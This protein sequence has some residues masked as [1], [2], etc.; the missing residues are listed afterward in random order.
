MK[1]RRYCDE[2]PNPKEDNEGRFEYLCC[3][4][5]PDGMGHF[6]RKVDILRFCVLDSC[7]TLDINQENCIVTHWMPMPHMP[8]ETI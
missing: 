2:Y 1:W 4:L 5:V 8:E 3:V 7:W 6:S